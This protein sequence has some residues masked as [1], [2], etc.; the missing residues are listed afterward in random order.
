[1]ARAFKAMIEGSYPY[2][3]VL[4]TI[5]TDYLL[6]LATNLNTGTNA[7]CPY[8]SLPLLSPSPTAKQTFKLNCSDHAARC[9]IH[10]ITLTPSPKSRTSGRCV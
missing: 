10:A 9:F 8:N 3:Q 5:A 2:G 1:M 7:R 4:E 6:V